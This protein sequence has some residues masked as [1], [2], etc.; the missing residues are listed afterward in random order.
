MPE[1]MPMS[2]LEKTMRINTTWPASMD[3]PA[4]WSVINTIVYFRRLPDEDK[5]RELLCPR[6]AA[7]RRLSAIAHEDGSW[8][9]VRAD[10]LDLGYHVHREPAS[11]SDAQLRETVERIAAE[12]LD[13]SKPPW[14][15]HLVPAGGKAELSAVV[16][17]VHH[18]VG[19][20]VHLN[21]VFR[22]VVELA[23]GTTL[24]AQDMRRELE[25]QISRR[26]GFRRALRRVGGGVA[27]GALAAPAFFS[28]LLASKGRL[29]PYAEA[30]HGPQEA[31]LAGNL[32]G[33]RSICLVPAHSLSFVKACKQKLHCTVNDVLLA[34]TA[35]ALRRYC[36]Q[37]GDPT[38]TAGQP[39]K[40]TFRCL[41]PV[42]LPYRFP[43][44]HD[45]KDRLTN[46][47]CFC[48]AALPVGEVNSVDRVKA[49]MKEVGR[50]K[51]SM[52]PLVGLWQLNSL[53][54]WLPLGQA[55]SVAKDL[56][57][58][59]SIVFSNVPGPQEQLHM[60]G[61]PMVGVQSLFYNV[62][63]QIILL[64]YNE[65]IWMNITADPERVRD[66]QSFAGHYFD[67]LR[68]LAKELSVEND[69]GVEEY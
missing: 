15:L 7:F 46:N 12:T 4:A 13:L 45:R 24:E 25:A 28:N 53:G 68:D 54:P 56:F 61:E 47:W 21:Q 40:A 32:A 37:Q 43:E 23:D 65:R 63:P 62:I 19:D 20:G 36:E 6:L 58:C 33:P 27:K 29:R 2:H 60:C 22:A 48:S 41:M 10:A 11:G 30:W 26:C 42:A 51:R 44:D 64:S 5:V 59:H 17:R 31:R 57:G 14:R 3:I 9:H 67:E 50:L 69:L 35:G 1:Q 38:F 8:E 18:C 16:F 34:A 66:L 52:K 49:V 55:Q 39:S